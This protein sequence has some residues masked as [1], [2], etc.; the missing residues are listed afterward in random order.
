MISA[1]HSYYNYYCSNLLATSRGSKEMKTKRKKKLLCWLLLVGG[2]RERRGILACSPNEAKALVGG[3]LEGLS[4]V[5]R[6]ERRGGEISLTK[7]GDGVPPPPTRR[8]QV[9]D[10]NGQY[11][12]IFFHLLP[13]E[14]R[15][16]IVQ[17]K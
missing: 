13:M 14:M 12:M 7:G 9:A 10:L 5:L 1:L 17:S 11:R 8:T 6:S 4:A 3:Q 2:W 15:H 16:N